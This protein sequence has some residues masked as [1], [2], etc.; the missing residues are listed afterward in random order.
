VKTTDAY[1]ET[2]SLEKVA[3]YSMLFQKILCPDYSEDE[4]K[5]LG[6][7]LMDEIPKLKGYSE[8]DGKSKIKM[9]AWLDVAWKQE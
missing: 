1:V 4:A 8:M 7:L 9:T 6:S 3:Q 5:R 2:E